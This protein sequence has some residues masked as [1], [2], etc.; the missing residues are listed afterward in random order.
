[1]TD[2]NEP[3]SASIRLAAVQAVGRRLG[4][5]PDPTSETSADANEAASAV[6]SAA[7]PVEEYIRTGQTYW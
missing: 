6:I 7:K 3:S 2:L 1:M 4:A 5:N